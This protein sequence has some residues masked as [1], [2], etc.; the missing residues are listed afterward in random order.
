M[1]QEL[2]QLCN[3]LNSVHTV[4]FYKLIFTYLLRHSAGFGFMEL[5]VT[6]SSGRTNGK[7][8]INGRDGITVL[9]I[10]FQNKNDCE[11]NQ[12]REAMQTVH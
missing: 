9:A 8:R 1:D 2:I 5:K 10:V 11:N 4:G 12:S 7:L 6:F 3:T